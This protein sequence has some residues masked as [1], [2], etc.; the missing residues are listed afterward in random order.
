LTADSH[1]VDG[2]L[3]NQAERVFDSQFKNVVRDMSKQLSGFVEWISQQDFYANTTIVILGDHLY[4]DST[5]F[6][7]G[8]RMQKM[9]NGYEDKYL[10]KDFAKNYNRYPLNIF[11][12][13]LLDSSSTKNRSF[14]HFDMFPAMIESIGGVFDSPGLA[15]GRSMTKGKT[16]LEQFGEAEMNRQ[17]RRKSDFYGALWKS[18]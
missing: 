16:L 4:Q 15:L 13:S 7:A 6:P 3:D 8:F 9:H 1:A 18:E 10:K 11:I 14:S 12:N 2:H 17:L 5:I